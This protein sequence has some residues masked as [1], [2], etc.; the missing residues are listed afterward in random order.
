VLF[1]SI[2]ASTVAA[3]DTGLDAEFVIAADPLSGGL[4]AIDPDTL[5]AVR[6]LPEVASAVGIYGDL[7]QIDGRSDFLA[8]I[9]DPAAATS[10][11]R[12]ETTAGTLQ[13]LGS[14]QA[15][16][17]DKTADE[18]GFH[19]GSTLSVKMARGE[20]ITVTVIGL[21]KR[22]ALVTRDLPQ[23]R[24]RQVGLQQSGSDPGLRRPRTERQCGQCV[25]QG[26]GCAQGQ[27]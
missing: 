13:P 3:I 16:M 1:A 9:D 23:R 15:I 20:P 18:R 26:A 25:Q 14:G 21:F 7:A 4:G 5:D 19:V 17:D 6:H 22:S 8:G 11:F 2:Q 10:M 27:S 24:R 12:L